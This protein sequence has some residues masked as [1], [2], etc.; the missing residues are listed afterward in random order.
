MLEQVEIRTYATF[1]LM[2][3][4]LDHEDVTRRLGI[5][6][7]HAHNAGDPRRPRFPRASETMRW[8]DGHWALSSRGQV[9]S[10]DLE[11]HIQWILDRLEPVMSGRSLLRGSTC[12][13]QVDVGQDRR[14]GFCMRTRLFFTSM[15]RQGSI[16]KRPA[17]ELEGGEE[18]CFEPPEYPARTPWPQA[19]DCFA[20]PGVPRS[21]NERT[22]HL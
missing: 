11:A 4:T 8:R 2:G 16:S 10:T 22:T 3:R 19:P 1:R 12:H 9:D 7:S 17:S 5:A 20:H 14:P 21:R 15:I 18:S 6:P 13:R